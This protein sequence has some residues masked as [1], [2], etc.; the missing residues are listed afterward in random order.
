MR[1]K[2]AVMGPRQEVVYDDT[3]W[4]ALRKLRIRAIEV[5]KTLKDSD[6]DGVVFGSVARG[7]VKP[8]SDIDIFIPSVVNSMRVGLALD[9]FN[10]LERSIVQATP[11][12]L[13]KAHITLEDNTTVVYPLIPPRQSE[14]EFYRFG[15]EVDL[16]GLL[17]DKRVC[18]V[19]KRLMF[20]EPT[21]EGHI[22]MPLSDMSPGLVAKR[23]RVG[24]SIVEERMRVLERR[25]DVGR[26]GIYL[27][28]ALA[29]D[30]GVEQV[31]HELL[32]E[33]PAMRRRVMSGH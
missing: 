19:D 8:S 11:R 1:H 25:A 31:F 29:P 5:L 20:I 3:I 6:I 14:I 12:A 18:G 9:R 4:E 13:I 24:Q 33:D 10:V 23:L 17:D 27:V 16:Q 26:T 15:G 21:P 22:E 2:T 7:D 30:E 32:S 28:R